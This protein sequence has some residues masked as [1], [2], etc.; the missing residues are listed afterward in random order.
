MDNEFQDPFQR[1][2]GSAIDGST[3]RMV[4]RTNRLRRVRPSPPRGVKKTAVGSYYEL[5]WEPPPPD[6]VF[7]HYRIRIGTD[8]GEPTFVVPRGT[9]RHHVI[10]GSTFYV[11]SYLETLDIESVAAKAA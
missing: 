4:A 10:T 8:S 1:G 5:S 9:T 7:T 6:V 3:G 11:S 2:I